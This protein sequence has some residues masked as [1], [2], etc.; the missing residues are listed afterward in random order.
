MHPQTPQTPTPIAVLDRVHHFQNASHTA[1]YSMIILQLIVIYNLLI[2]LYIT[3]C[4][5]IKAH[6]ELSDYSTWIVN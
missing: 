5:F 6:F 3:L 2:V 4:V 1:M